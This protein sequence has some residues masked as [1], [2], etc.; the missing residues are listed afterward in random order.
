MIKH[1][2]LAL[3]ILRLAP[4]AA[5]AQQDT[6]GSGRRRFDG[7]GGVLRDTTS[8]SGIED[9]PIDPSVGT[10]TYDLKTVTVT[11]GLIDT[12]AHVANHFHWELAGCTATSAA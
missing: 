7:K 10:V 8:W 4:A 11:P 6:I 5:F 9:R 3:A 2:R 12:H 1:A